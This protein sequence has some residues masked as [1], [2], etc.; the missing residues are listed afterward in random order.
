MIPSG[1]RA[2]QPRKLGTCPPRQ[3][4]GQPYARIFIP[5]E[6]DANASW[7]AAF[8]PPAGDVDGVCRCRVA[9]GIRSALGGEPAAARERARPAA[10]LVFS[11][12]PVVF[13]LICQRGI[14]VT[15]GNT[16][17]AEGVTVRYGGI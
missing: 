2:L 11:F 4:E 1:L 7:Y 6:P 8:R 15:T 5:K 3:S 10:G 13:H 16:C 12:C 17:V 9:S 14:D